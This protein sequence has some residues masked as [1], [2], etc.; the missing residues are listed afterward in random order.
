MKIKYLNFSKKSQEERSGIFLILFFIFILFSILLFSN[1]YIAKSGVNQFTELARS[2]I[3][4]KL[5]FLD[6][7]IFNNNVS[8]NVFFN[9][10]YYWPLGPFPAI[11]LIPF[12]LFF[13][14]LDWSIIFIQALVNIILVFLSFLLVFKIAQKN[15]YNCEDALFWAIAFVF[16]SAFA[17]VAFSPFS[18]FLAHSVSVFLLLLAFWEYFN[19]KRLLLIGLLMSLILLTRATAFLAILFFAADILFSEKGT[20]WKIKIKKL[21]ELSFFPF[22]ALLLLF[23]YNYLRFGDFFDQGYM[24]QILT[25]GFMLD[26]ENYGLFNLKYLPRGLYYSLF[27]APLPIISSET[28]ILTFPFIKANPWGMSIFFTSPYLLYLFF[29]KKIDK[30]SW[31]L[32]LNSLFIFFL[33]TSSFFIGY[34]QFGFRYSLDFFP[35]LFLALISVY[36]K[37]NDKMSNGL[38]LTIIISAL[39]NLYL[40]F[41]FYFK[42]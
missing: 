36:R 6:N 32:I 26:K 27:S 25:A 42:I 37:N 5:Y 19:K 2:F 22:L 14:F 18:W 13:L 15:K 12:F 24:G 17:G 8:D 7:S 34:S 31:F 20:K 1:F 38:K 35:L 41:P 40:L 29:A 23:L 30:K 11:A 28:H 16:A 4:G 9:G 33:I 3:N 21:I 10:R 39:L